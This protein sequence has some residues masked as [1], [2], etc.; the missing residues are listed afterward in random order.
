MADL[1]AAIDA[2]VL[3]RRCYRQRTKPWEGLAPSEQEGWREFFD[4]A[5]RTITAAAAAAERE[6]IRQLAT[7]HE[8][9]F[10]PA[11]VRSFAALL[12]EGDTT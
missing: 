5:A 11:G 9:L 10:V 2:Y 6:R 12:T 8:R 4:A 7:E 1:P 3:F